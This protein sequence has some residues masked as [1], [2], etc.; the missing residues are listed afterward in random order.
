MRKAGLSLRLLPLRL[1]IGNCK[2]CVFLDN[3]KGSVNSAL[4]LLP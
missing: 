1:D 2:N 3:T 4:S